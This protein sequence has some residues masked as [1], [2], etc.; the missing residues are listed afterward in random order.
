M[1]KGLISGGLV[2]VVVAG[3]SF[4]VAS[5]MLDPPNRDGASEPSVEV[6]EQSPEP[7]EAVS[8]GS[9]ETAGA[10]PS[11]ITPAPE[12][13]EPSEVAPA[14]N[15]EILIDPPAMSAPAV[16]SSAPIAQSNGSALP[17]ADT[18]SSERPEV[19][20]TEG[21]M[22]VPEVEGSANVQVASEEPV[23]PNPAA[24]APATPEGEANLEVQ[25]EPLVIVTEEP[26]APVAE[27]PAE[28][29]P[30][31]MPEAQAVDTADEA[32]NA[33]GMET[34][35]AEEEEII[36]LTATLTP[37]V[38]STKPPTSLSGTLASQMPSGAEGVK[39]NRLTQGDSDAVG[40]EVSALEAYAAAFSNPNDLPLMSIVLIDDGSMVG[41]DA[42][43]RGSP[44]PVTVA[45]DPSLPDASDRMQTYRDAG[46]EVLAI[47]NIAQGA[48][49]SDVE[50]LLGATFHVLPEAIGFIDTGA[51]DFG[52]AAST[53]QGMAALAA[54]GR[55]F[56]T[57]ARGLNTSL[58]TAQE[59]EV[60][61]ALVYRDLDAED[62]SAQV[63]RRFL[64]QAA[65]RAR[66][67]SGVILLGRVRPDT[68]SALI[69]WATANRAEQV[70][71]APV[72]AVLLGK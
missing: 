59:A 52:S 10:A 31:E 3:A 17:S 61:A 48:S 33:G 45:L 72:S 70:A 50:M 62:Q 46:I 4:S 36:D 53:E 29:T 56:V 60:P 34:G 9:E 12:T 40:E 18:Q 71:Q 32:M 6:T 47:G 38:S 57:I 8:A 24:E 1:L 16:G 26:A 54:E 25:V 22:G 58:R 2:G 20:G 19:T 44:F 63:I 30:V 66:Q 15:T 35:P 11:E 39:V 67:E 69:L 68:L 37:E 7:I 41:A 13:A 27:E 14:Q 49:A 23:L 55:G 65:F 21:V 28:E 5:L 43:L 42:A 51:G 64:D